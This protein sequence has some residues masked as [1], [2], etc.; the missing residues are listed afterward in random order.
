MTV[1]T[2]DASLVF[3]DNGRP[4]LPELSQGHVYWNSLARQCFQDEKLAGSGRR[5]SD[6]EI[7][8]CHNYR[9]TPD[10]VRS[11]EYLGI[12]DFVH[13]GGDV[14]RLRWQN[15][16]KL[17]LVLDHLQNNC[18]AKYILHLD[19][20]DVLVAA[21]PMI[22]L[23]R[24]LEEFD[25]G[26]LFNCEKI[27][28]PGSHMRQGAAIPDALSNKNSFFLNV[29]MMWFGNYNL[30]LDDVEKNFRIE[31]FER[32]HSNTVFPHLNSGCYIGRR[33]YLIELLSAAIAIKGFIS[34][35][36]FNTSDQILVRENYRSHFPD[37]QIDDNC[38]IFQ[39]MYLTNPAEVKSTYALGGYRENLHQWWHISGGIQKMPKLTTRKLRYSLGL[40]RSKPEDSKGR[41]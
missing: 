35:P 23:Q 5:P 6:L 19:A 33:D 30:A 16:I 20:G 14:P 13:L 22:I 34:T 1:S 32:A 37:L 10:T 28:S 3:H 4:V 41:Q 11:L 8:V 2:Q 29:A 26:A 15:F 27:S 36:S 39:C 24:F 12:N 17:Q 18:S 38:R 25:C 21:D 40:T 31:A 9:D 7:I